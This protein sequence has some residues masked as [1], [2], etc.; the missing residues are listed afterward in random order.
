MKDALLYLMILLYILAG[1]YHFIRPTFYKRIMPPWIPWHMPIVYISGVC[2]IV[3][4]I[5][6]FPMAT[7]VF[8]AWGIII[9]LILIFPANIRMMLNFR[10]RKN[11]Y[12]W[13]TI[14]R[15]PLQLVL[16]WW[17]WQYTA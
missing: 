7:R 16:V 15:L 8:A 1:S 12:L 2:E 14:L 6:L 5:L 17:A 9:L 11:P 13:I 4:A 10:R 3:L